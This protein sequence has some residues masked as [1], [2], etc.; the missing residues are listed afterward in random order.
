M[1]GLAR[2]SLLALPLL[3]VPAIGRAV[4]I[5]IPAF[6]LWVGRTA[7]LRGDTASARLLFTED[8]T[9]MM[10]VKFF[11][12]CYALPVRSWRFEEDGMSVRYSRVSALNSSRL[13][14]G[15]AHILRDENHVV[16]IEA[17]RHVAE[18]DGF[19]EARLAASC[20]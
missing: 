15:E 7:L 18:F 10:S 5:A 14:Q 20:G 19:A 3:M 6:P 9:G 4:G 13:I 8:G 12:L 2:R 17:A 11:F 16:W 1:P